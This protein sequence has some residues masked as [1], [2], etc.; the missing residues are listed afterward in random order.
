[1]LYF[2]SGTD[3]AGIANRLDGQK[4]DDEYTITVPDYVRHA[5]STLKHG[6]R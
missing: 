1:M 4:V 5:S 3:M 6:D 2:A